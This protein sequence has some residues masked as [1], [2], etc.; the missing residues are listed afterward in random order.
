M[1]D[2]FV[3]PDLV[4][5]SFFFSNNASVRGILT[6]CLLINNS[7]IKILFSRNISGVDEINET[8]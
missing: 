3:I 4:P 1:F 6:V 8:K 7:R 5:V 2:L